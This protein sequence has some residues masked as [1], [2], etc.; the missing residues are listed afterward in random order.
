MSYIV[1]RD[2]ST[3]LQHKKR[4]THSQV[5]MHGDSRAPHDLLCPHPQIIGTSGRTNLYRNISAVAKVNQVFA[6]TR[7]QDITL[8]GSAFSGTHLL[9]K[10]LR[11]SHRTHGEKKIS[12]FLFERIHKSPKP[13][14]IFR[15]D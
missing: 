9:W 8:T 1:Q 6:F 11:K 7:A 13:A 2:G 10:H 14:K 4:F 5:S 12:P 15:P 3:T